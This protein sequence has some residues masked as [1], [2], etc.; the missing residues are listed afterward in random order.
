VATAL[1][2]ALDARGALLAV[3]TVEDCAVPPA[4][5]QIGSDDETFALPLANP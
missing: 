5:M 1:D 2:D 4:M 3:W